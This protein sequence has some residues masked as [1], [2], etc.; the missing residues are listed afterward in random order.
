MANPLRILHVD[1]N[2]FDRAVVLGVLAHELEDAFVHQVADEPGLIDA[3]E[4]GNFDV[5][6][7]D[8]LLPWIDGLAILRLCKERWPDVPVLMV[9]GSGDEEV[10]IQAMKAGLDDYILKSPKHLARLPV[11]IKSALDRVE[12]RERLA[13]SEVRFRDLFSRV[14]VGLYRSTRDGT[15]VDV[16]PTLAEILGYP[17]RDALMAVPVLDL[18]VDATDR[19]RWQVQI[20]RDGV[21]RQF[22][23]ALRRMDGSVA[24]VRGGARA[25]RDAEGRIIG[26]EGSV[27][28]VTER[29]RAEV[30]LAR[31]MRQLDTMRGAT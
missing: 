7:T 28:D 25:V 10:A 9:T 20:E 3:L 13:A 15:F 2:A 16:N 4:A 23:T 31:R 1:D 17:T 27:E 6:L 12:Q 29:K 14:P 26:Y 30:A 21:V 19:V 11:A 5:V 18:Y 8:Y 22:E 24:W